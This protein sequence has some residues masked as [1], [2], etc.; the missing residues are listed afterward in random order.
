MNRKIK[1]RLRDKDNNIVGYE[2]WYCGSYLKEEKRFDANPC[3]LY[4]TDNKYWTPKY[5]EHRYKDQFVEL[6]DK[7]EKEIFEGDICK[8]YKCED[9]ST[10]FHGLAYMNNN[11]VGGEWKIIRCDNVDSE[12]SEIK[13]EECL[14]STSF[15]NDNFKIIGNIYENKELLK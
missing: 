7:H 3:W 14:D 6:P 2:K 12:I 8:F 13:G 11:V 15:W 10:M 5:I 1:F 9:D 4:S